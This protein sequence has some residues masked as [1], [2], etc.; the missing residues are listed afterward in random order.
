MVAFEK[1]DFATVRRLA[2]EVTGQFAAFGAAAL[3]DPVKRG[4]LLN[5]ASALLAKLPPEMSQVHEV[6]RWRARIQQIER[7]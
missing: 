2:A 1:D 4:A 5:E 3:A 6:R 7:R